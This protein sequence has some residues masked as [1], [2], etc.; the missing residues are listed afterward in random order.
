MITSERACG[1][2]RA[3]RGPRGGRSSPQSS[4]RRARRS[5]SRLATL[6]NTERVTADGAVR[7]ASATIAWFLRSRPTGGPGPARRPGRRRGRE[8]G[9]G[10]DEDLRRRRSA[11]PASR[12][13]RGRRRGR[14]ARRSARI[15]SIACRTR[16]EVARLVDDDPGR[17]VGGD[18]ADLAAGRQVLSASIAAC[19]GR[20]R[21][22]PAA[23]SV[24]AMLADV[25]IDQD[26]VAGEAR[27]P[28]EERPCGEE[29]E[30]RSRA[31][32]GA[33]TAGSDGAAATARSPRRRRPAGPQ[34]R[35]RHD[36]LGRAAA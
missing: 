35:R 25:S 3:R 34:Q 7:T 12:R 2:E 27:G 24:A 1:V 28:L 13:A 30:E 26:D 20:R 11:P 5:R 9:V 32:A 33:A 19:L 29:R 18:H 4:S 21:A 14:P 8:R 23:T 22:G 36:R 16:P 17:P 6:T 15:D 10:R 31:A